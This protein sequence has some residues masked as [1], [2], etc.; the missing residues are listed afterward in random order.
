LENSPNGTEVGTL[1]TTDTDFLTDFVF[2]YTLVPGAGDADNS[3]FAIAGD[4]LVVNGPIDFEIQNLFSIRVR[5]TDAGGLSVE[6]ILTV[7][8][9]DMNE[10]ATVITLSNNILPENELPGY[11]IGTLSN[12]DPDAGDSVAYTLVSGTGDDDNIMFKIDGDKLQ[13]AVTFNFEARSQYFL[14]VRATDRAGLFT[15]QPFV[16][17]VTDVNEAPVSIS[18]S[19]DRVLENMPAGT[20]VG[21]VS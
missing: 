14:R 21:S 12:N 4:K 13:S 17:T 11:E 16:I 15:E 10:G 9:I 3:T 18:L 5:S 6:K 8:A 20:F 7:A 1:K 19:D 2:T